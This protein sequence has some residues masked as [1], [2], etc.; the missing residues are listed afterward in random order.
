MEILQNFGLR[1]KT[2]RQKQNISQEKLA[3]KADLHRTYIY[4]VES[5]KRNISLKNIHKLSKAL[6]LSLEELFK[7]L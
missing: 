2:L 1:I 7:N 3:E 4:L 6:G 5:G